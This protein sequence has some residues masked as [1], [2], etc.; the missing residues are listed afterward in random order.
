MGRSLIVQELVSADGFVAETD[1]GLEFFGAVPDFGDI[2]AESIE[3]LRAVDTVL[4]GA[5]TYRLFVDF[6]P[7]S[8]EIVA[9][10]VNTT[11]KF[12]YSKSLQAAPWG[13]WKPATVVPGDAVEHVR[14]LKREPGGT[15]MVWGSI[16]I[17]R[18]L[19]AAGLVDELQL[20]VLPV[21]IG[22]GRTLFT[23][24]TGRK[25]LTLR[26]SKQ[27]ASGVAALRYGAA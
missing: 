18:A 24:A 21:V 7:T 4:L 23:A 17:A 14:A 10:A 19:F 22:T 13:S 3:D 5:R 15:I 27:Y 12:V 1:G 11:H 6:W 9:E 25:V 20:R 8:E 16:S 26:E 2:D